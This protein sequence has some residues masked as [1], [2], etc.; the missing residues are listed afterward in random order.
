MMK[1]DEHFMLRVRGQV[2]T[3]IKFSPK[4]EGQQGCDCLKKRD[5]LMEICQ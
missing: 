2:K 4:Q 5:V 1:L 3:T